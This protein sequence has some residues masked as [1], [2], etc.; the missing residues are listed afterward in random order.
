MQR[1]EPDGDRPG[2]RPVASGQRLDG[3][4]NEHRVREIAAAE[5]EHAHEISPE[6]A[7]QQPQGTDE[8]RLPEYG[9]LAF[10]DERDDR[11][12]RQ[13]AGNRREP[14]NNVEIVQPVQAGWSE[15]DDRHRR[16]RTSNRAGGVGRLI[17]PKCATSRRCGNRIREDG[18]VKRR[19]NSASR[20]ADRPHEKIPGP[21]GEDSVK[22][23]R[24]ACEKVACGGPGP[25]SLDTVAQPAAQKLGEA[26]QPVGYALHQTHAAAGAPIAA[27]NNGRIDVPAS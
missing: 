3:V 10:D 15:S 5:D 4:E 6:G 19:S 16:Q 21:P 26:R 20:P 7:R 8:A 11:N 27:R 13:N 24:H 22:A 23:G 1:V 2:A 12:R 14:E 25:A 18:V 17:E 9:M